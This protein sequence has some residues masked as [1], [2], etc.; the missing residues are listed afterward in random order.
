MSIGDA[1]AKLHSRLK[2]RRRRGF[3]WS[4]TS[5]VEGSA[6]WEGHGFSRALPN[7]E[8]LGRRHALRSSELI[9]ISE[10]L[11]TYQAGMLRGSVQGRYQRVRET[12]I[13]PGH[14]VESAFRRKVK[15]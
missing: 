7:T 4:V 1:E 15:N 8:R 3:R 5:E 14:D 11:M 12:M 10:V 13:G 2:A 6:A 9:A